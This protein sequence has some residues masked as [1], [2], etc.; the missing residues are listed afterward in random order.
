MQENSES[1][2]SSQRPGPRAG[3][4]LL[5]Y[6]VGPETNCYRVLRPMT[7]AY[8]HRITCIRMHVCVCVCACR[9][10]V[11]VCA[12]ARVCV[13]VFLWVGRLVGVHYDL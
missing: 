2:S 6:R 5:Y 4:I 7:R 12:R 1:P 9:V 8:E 11:D 10:L 13:Y 3:L